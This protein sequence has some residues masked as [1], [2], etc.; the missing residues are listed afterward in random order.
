MNHLIHLKPPKHEGDLLKS[1]TVREEVV[2]L[3]AEVRATPMK[4]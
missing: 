4:A 3:G 1:H 2:V